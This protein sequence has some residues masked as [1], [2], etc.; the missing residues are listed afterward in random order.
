M[1]KNWWHYTSMGELS[2]ASWM[3]IFL[4]LMDIPRFWWILAFWHV[5]QL[6]SSYG[7]ELM[8]LYFLVRLP[9][10]LMCL[11]WR[12]GGIWWDRYW[13]SWRDLLFHDC[14]QWMQGPTHSLLHNWT[15]L[16]E[17]LV[18]L[19][20]FDVVVALYDKHTPHFH[21]TTIPTCTHVEV[22]LMDQRYFI[23]GERPLHICGG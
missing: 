9:W 23:I 13:F 22:F 18:S 1:D 14:M 12:Y 7:R 10:G 20:Y 6:I 11:S 21:I 16:L 4:H 19:S 17:H 5:S 8:A 15:P 2:Q 3:V